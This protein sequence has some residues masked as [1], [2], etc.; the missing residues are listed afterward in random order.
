MK[1]NYYSNYQGYLKNGNRVASFG[2][3]K[4]GKLEMFLLYC[5]KH[6]PF[7]KHTAKQLYEYYLENGEKR[8][9]FLFP[10]YHPVI[11]LLP[12]NESDSASYTFQNYI[13]KNFYKKRIKTALCLEECLIK[14]STKIVTK[15]KKFPKLLR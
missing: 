7:S 4:E 15:T 1:N 8:M 13:R 10:E 12:I 2:I 9:K 5:S 3:E 11:L 14:G 6:D